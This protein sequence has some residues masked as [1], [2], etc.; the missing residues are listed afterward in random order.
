MRD[1]RIRANGTI[2]PKPGRIQFEGYEVKK[3]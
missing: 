1:R 3:R 2:D